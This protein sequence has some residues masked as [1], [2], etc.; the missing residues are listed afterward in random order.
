M[1]A[2]LPLEALKPAPAPAG[3]PT[4]P[5]GVPPDGAAPDEVSTLL[6]E[7]DAR[8]WYRRPLPWLGVA[9]A[10]LVLAGAAWWWTQ[11]A[12]QAMPHYTTQPVSRGDLTL[13][14]T[15]N[16][17]VQ[18]TRS[19]SIGSEL[20][21]TVLLVGVDV[22]DRIKKGQVLLVLDT[23]K[24]RDQILRSQAG[25]AAAR[26]RSLLTA[27]TVAEAGASLARL[28]A[29]ARLSG[30]QVPSVAELD[31][32]RAVLARAQA[33]VGSARAGVDEAL[34]TL[35]TDQI[36]LSKA[37][38][39]A[40]SDGVVLTRSVDPGNAV[41]ASL[42]AVTLFTVAEDL[43]RLRLWV[44]VDE[45]DVGVVKAGQAASFT[46]SAYPA[47]SF[48]ARI[49][50][51]GFGSTITDNVVTYLTWLDV[52]N[53]DL[54]LRPG[55]TATATIVATE[56][57]DVLRVPNAALRYTPTTAAADAKKGIASGVA[58]GPPK[59]ESQ[60]KGAAD[61]AST[62]G[63]RQVWV[64]A[65]AP[66]GQPLPDAV[67]RAV[68]VTPGISDGRSTEIVAGALS[69]G[70]LVITSQATGAPK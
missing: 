2:P 59:T 53:T 15:A 67:P 11:R 48:P 38:I 29:V 22:N 39:T 32:G 21:G 6:G 40:P 1:N 17:T 54:S 43:A 57:K 60:R 64:L 37:S 50:R 30:G 33:E 9:A 61:S 14:V 62:A 7:A 23:A 27:A 10:L 47:R 25:V 65:T 63:A 58:L 55:M 31:A 20:S 16:G 12:A 13:S 28:E 49:T 68:A 8:P 66:D 4:P 69:E 42:Q 24:L 51:V 52:D 44:Y 3:E 26:S 70:M 19:V 5:P 36:N 56:R 34:A 18:P 41:A 35:S 46:V 45:A